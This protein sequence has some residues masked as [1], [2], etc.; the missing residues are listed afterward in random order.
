MS[1]TKPQ[2]ISGEFVITD[3]DNGGKLT[4]QP[5]CLDTQVAHSPNRTHKPH[6]LLFLL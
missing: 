3:N 4:S 1:P 5:H 6:F 2:H